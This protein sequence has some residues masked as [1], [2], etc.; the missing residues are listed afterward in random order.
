MDFNWVEGVT[1]VKEIIRAI[2]SD[3]TL[4]SQNKWILEYPSDINA[5]DNMAI[6]STQTSF[7]ITNYIKINRPTDVLNYM[8]IT[9]GDKLNTESTDIDEER[10]SIPARFAWYKQSSDVELFEWGSVQYWLS[11]CADYAN[12]ILQGDPSLDIAPYDNYLISYAYIGAL[13]S[14][15]GADMDDKY[16]FGITVSS[17]VFY[18]DKNFP[19]KYGK[20]TATCV[21]DVGMLGTRTGTPF[22]AHLPKF[23][24]SWEF[25]DK[26]FISSSQWTH[27][28]HM[29]D[30]IIYHAYD[31]ERG[32][33]QNVLIGD[34]SAI[35][36]LDTLIIDKGKDTEKQY[37][38][39]NINAPYSILNNGPNVLYGVAVRKR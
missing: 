16:N 8:L 2:A 35:F 32:K 38:M 15:E 7:G 22:Q 4:A 25:T 37:V 30:I 14:F 29:S 33:L 9:I 24:T 34:R 31:R 26:N 28:Y 20:R 5:I 13:E 19:E 21:T 36:H 12:I 39:F 3:L 23:S 6:L 18:S 17:D 1:T 11:F 10:S 27:K